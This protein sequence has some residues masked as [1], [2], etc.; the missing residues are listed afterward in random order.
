MGWVGRAR[1]SHMHS[2]RASISD[3]GL[4]GI[5]NRT[6]FVLDEEGTIEYQWVTDDST[7]EPGYDELLEAIGSA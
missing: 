1:Y 6:A 5:S 4:H 2:P 7:N 3:L